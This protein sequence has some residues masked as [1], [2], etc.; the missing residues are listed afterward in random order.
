MMGSMASIVI[1][2]GSLWIHDGSNGYVGWFL[3]G[4][5]NG[6]GLSG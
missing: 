3:F 1:G 4:S 6:F 5:R 2:F